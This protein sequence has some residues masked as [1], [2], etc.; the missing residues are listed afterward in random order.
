MGAR[1]GVGGLSH[2]EGGCLT[3][4]QAVI[5]SGIEKTNAFNGYFEKELG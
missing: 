5:R 3:E 2:G 4:R 1:A